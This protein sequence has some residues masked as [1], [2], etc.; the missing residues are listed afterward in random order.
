[1]SR[2]SHARRESRALRAFKAAT[3]PIVIALP[4]ATGWILAAQAPP[5]GLLA[6]T[7][8]TALLVWFTRIHVLA[9]IAAGAAAGALGLI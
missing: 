6:L 5:W 4:L 2:W 9:L 1:V 8:A 7:A 3:A